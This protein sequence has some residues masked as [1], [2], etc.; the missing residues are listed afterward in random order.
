MSIRPVHHQGVAFEI[1][2]NTPA[3]LLNVGY[4]INDDFLCIITS[5]INPGLRSLFRVTKHGIQNFAQYHI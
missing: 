3:G 5:C 2:I 4:G 1:S